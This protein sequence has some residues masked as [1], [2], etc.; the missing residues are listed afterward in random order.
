M[1]RFL[2]PLS[3]IGLALLIGGAAWWLLSTIDRARDADEFERQI[4]EMRAEKKAAG[5]FAEAVGKLTSAVDGRMATFIRDANKNARQTRER[6]I[7]EVP[8]GSPCF[9]L[10]TVRLLNG[11]A[12]RGP[13]SVPGAPGDPEPVQPSTTARAVP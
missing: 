3:Y 5:E 4:I 8:T 13:P 1:L 7:R 11:S 2:E 10:D 9:G 6:I 12:R